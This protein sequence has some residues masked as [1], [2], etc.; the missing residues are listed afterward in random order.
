MTNTS[1]TIS[2]EQAER[3]L[4]RLGLV[5]AA[6]LGFY[7]ATTLWEGGDIVRQPVSLL[8]VLAFFLLAF[9][10]LVAAA[11]RTLPY[12]AVWIIPAM[13]GLA[14]LGIAYS[15]AVNQVQS[16]S[17]DSADVY[18]FSD[19][20]AHL[21]RIGQNPY[22]FDLGDAYRVYRASSTLQTPTT[23]GN[24]VGKMVYPALSFLLFVPFQLLGI[25][26][27]LIFALFYWLALLTV[28]IGAPRLIRPVILLPL[29]IEPRYLF[30][31]LGGVSDA[32]WAFLICLMIVSWRNK[33]V[34]AIWFGLACA[35]KQQ[36]WLLVP[37]L[38]IRILRESEADERTF[39]LLDVLQFFLIA[40][41][42]FA[43]INL[44]YI[45]W[46]FPAWLAGSVSP[47][48][49]RM[50]TL[51]QGLSS[52]TTQGIVIIPRSLYTGY[53]LLAYTVCIVVYWRHYH[54][55]K[56]LIWLIPGLV[57]WLGQRSLSSYW[58]FNLLPFLLGLARDAL[59]WAQV[60]PSRL[61]SWRPTAAI[62]A[63]AAAFIVVTM[64]AFRAA[65]MPLSIAVQR[66]I[67][68]DGTTINRLTI[69]VTNNS[70][71]VISPRFSV[72]SWTNQPYF[73]DIQEGSPALAPGDSTFYRIRT[74]VPGEMVDLAR[75]AQVIVT[76]TGDSLRA[77]EILSGDTAF[78]S[79]DAVPNG[80][81][82]YQDR[83]S[84][85][86]TLWG[87][88]T[89]P[90]LSGGSVSLVDSTQ[91]GHAVRLTLQP[92]SPEIRAVAMLDTWLALPE[93]P[94][95]A[96]V[97]PPSDANRAPNFDLIYGL[98]LLS[99]FDNQRAWVLFGDG[100]ASGMIEPD[101]PYLML[102]TP[103][104]QWTQ[105]SINVRGIFQTLG[106]EVASPQW[107]QTRF[108][109]LNFPKQM[110]N[111][112]LLLAARQG[113]STLV[114][115]DFGPVSAAQNR[116]DPQLLI[117]QAVADPYQ[118]AI[119]RGDV[120]LAVH[121][122]APAAEYYRAALKLNPDSA[123]AYF[124]LGEIALRAQNWTEAAAYFENAL[125]LSYVR[126]ALAY[127][128]LA[129]ATYQQ[130][131]LDQA[132]AHAETALNAVRER[133]FFYDAVM[134]AEMY[135]VSGWIAFDQGRYEVAQAAFSEALRQE[136]RDAEA[137]IGLA[138][139]RL[140]LGDL[141][142]AANAVNTALDLGYSGTLP[143]SACPYAPA[144][145]PLLASKLVQFSG[146]CSGN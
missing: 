119:M 37:F 2:L 63:G 59:P 47:F 134:I 20:S 77:S 16:T 93:A 132:Q 22:Q 124:G 104:G 24:F 49:D 108:D 57:L 110:V 41:G 64:I 94:L 27:N 15:R 69:R 105:Q 139:V 138:L 67:Q 55:L 4:V 125:R 136:N 111:F 18:L 122:D 7:V 6:V 100:A 121:N 56:S 35:F 83:F 86:P 129:W 53:I 81:F 65:G 109:N 11:L 51:G 87:L 103:R 91:F 144:L 92:T 34:S 36:P 30:Y 90:A 98:E 68:T 21:V 46:D 38:A 29:L 106:I 3:F 95:S 126:A 17:Y 131:A 113:D 102:P 140:A 28:F 112:R 13:S 58:Y 78:I 130:G 123:E 25:P 118:I 61:R 145:S 85:A 70:D 60:D 146:E 31:A 76:D 33:P 23:D 62:V 117:Q 32:V 137:Y 107:I 8:L 135:R 42:V 44:P 88:V 133:V 5:G 82:E 127:R 26:T 10:L 84:G 52:L 80:R 73:W 1:L 40:G 39:R 79:M 115:A 66:P 19:Y 74:D 120:S 50:I 43:V 97:N 128:G 143:V 142:G 75:G 89:V 48:F 116:A 101:L 14:L 99:T 45:L 72:Q 71:R 96:W 9:G 141:G 54:S 114:E 12:R